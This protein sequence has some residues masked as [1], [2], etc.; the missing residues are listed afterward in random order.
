MTAFSPVNAFRTAQSFLEAAK[1]ELL[2][3]PPP[4]VSLTA[5]FL[6]CRAIELGL[7]SYLILHGATLAGLK[8]IGHDLAK[9]ADVAKAAG[10]DHACSLPVGGDAAVRAINPY[11][12]TKDLEY[13]TTGF[14]SYPASDVLI[15][16][17]EALLEGLERPIRSWRPAS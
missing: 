14:K 6:V 16:Y 17:A 9:A 13:V 8:R 5:Y 3:S 11:Y 4:A 1:R 12:S 15:Q 2:H 7:R 10:L